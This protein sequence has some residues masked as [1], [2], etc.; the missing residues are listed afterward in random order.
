MSM[1]EFFARLG[2]TGQ[3]VAAAVGVDALLF[4]RVDH[5]RQPLPLFVAEA[6]APVV[7]AQV[8]EVIYAAGQWT[9]SEDEIAARP[10]PPDPLYGESI[11]QRP[12]VPTG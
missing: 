9:T 10:L 5:G 6:I 12:I 11:P 1:A 4:E 3:A 8:G 7:G 2:T